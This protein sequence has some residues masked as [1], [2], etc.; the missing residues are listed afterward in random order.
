MRLAATSAVLCA[1]FAMATPA[2]RFPVPPKM[3]LA[4]ASCIHQ[5]E[6]VDWHW[7]P[8]HHPGQTS[9]N[10]YYGGF[11][12]VLSTWQ[13]LF[14]PGEHRGASFYRPDSASPSE[15]R[16]RAYK[17]WLRNGHS[18]GANHQWPTSASECGV[19]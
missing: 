19:P 8:T 2:H 1:V 14:G 13:S 5:H 12:F 18:F 17:A 16:W 4:Q 7:G 10:G 15:Q 9:W 3:W 11:Q 6:S